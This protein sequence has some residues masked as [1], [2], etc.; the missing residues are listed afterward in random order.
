MR[1][2]IDYWT[3]FGYIFWQ[4]TF[5]G[6]HHKGID[7]IAPT[8]TKIYASFNGT[9]EVAWSWGGGRQITLTSHDKVY[10]ARYM[11]LSDSLSNGVVNC[12]DIIG[13]VGNTG[14]LTTGSHLH[15]DL[16]RHGQWVNPLDYFDNKP[17]SEI[18]LFLKNNNMDTIDDLKKDLAKD[19]VK[20]DKRS[21]QDMRDGSIWLVAKKKKY[22]I[23]QKKNLAG[24]VALI[25]SLLGASKL[26]REERGFKTVQDK[27]KV[28]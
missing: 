24:D 9:M 11:H 21:R 26:T 16:Q 2:P 17:L 10:K 18:D 3:G 23:G 1:Y 13:R 8:G 27:K 14:V 25:A 20:K 28:L 5:Y 7:F 22:K 12:G 19:F 15:F 6:V 4:W